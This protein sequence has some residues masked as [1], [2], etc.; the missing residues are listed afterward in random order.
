LVPALAADNAVVNEE[1]AD[2]NDECASGADETLA[3][4][5]VVALVLAV[6]ETAR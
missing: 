4:I 1:L 2:K 6:A 5:L 3:W